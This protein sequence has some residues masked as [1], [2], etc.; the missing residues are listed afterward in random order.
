VQ[1]VFAAQPTIRPLPDA[2]GNRVAPGLLVR[3]STSLSPETGTVPSRSR[4]D[5]PPAEEQLELPAPLVS[6]LL[7]ALPAPSLPTLQQDMQQFLGAL[8]HAGR[9]LAQHPEET[10]LLPWVLTGVAA[11]AACELAR[12]QVLRSHAAATVGLLPTRDSLSEPP[13]LG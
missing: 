5:G 6:G 10:A 7:G 8:E 11:A 9:Q 3:E 13:G 1:A 2:G 4:A 12:R